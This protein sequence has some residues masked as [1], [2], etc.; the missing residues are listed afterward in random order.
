MASNVQAAEGQTLVGV[1]ARA[2]PQVLFGWHGGAAREATKRLYGP[3]AFKPKHKISPLC[4]SPRT[5]RPVEFLVAFAFRRDPS[6]AIQAQEGRG[7][8]PG[9]EIA[10][11]CFLLFCWGRAGNTKELKHKRAAAWDSHGYNREVQKMPP[12]SNASRHDQT[13]L[14][15]LAGV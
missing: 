2:P 5:S 11:C 13:G 14:T 15:M 1:R 4:R 12:A 10:A 3:P 9:E 8:R 6:D 7:K